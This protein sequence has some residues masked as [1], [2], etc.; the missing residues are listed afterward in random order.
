MWSQTQ[1]HTIVS[2][3]YWCVLVHQGCLTSLIAGVVARHVHL[4]IFQFQG[5]STDLQW[6]IG[7]VLVLNILKK[8]SE[9]KYGQ[10]KS[11]R[12]Y[13]EFWL[14]PP[15]CQITDPCFLWRYRAFYDGTVTR[16][17]IRTLGRVTRQLGRVIRQLRRVPRQLGRFRLSSWPNCLSH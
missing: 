4:Q 9:V 15:P 14:K 2:W 13:L 17:R 3:S 8:P 11:K 1:I 16:R 6:Q 12:F 7:K 5:K 10:P